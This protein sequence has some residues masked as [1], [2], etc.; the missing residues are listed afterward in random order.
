[1]TKVWGGKQTT[2]IISVGQ[3]QTTVMALIQCRTWHM[4]SQVF[5]QLFYRMALSGQNHV[6]KA[7]NQDVVMKA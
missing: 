3:T 2:F 4:L 6:T 7:L 1:M 5:I